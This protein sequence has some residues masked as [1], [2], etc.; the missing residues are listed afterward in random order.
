MS[1]AEGLPEGLGVGLALAG[2]AGHV[3]VDV[4]GAVD[5]QVVPVLLQLHCIQAL[6]QRLPHVVVAVYDV[7]RKRQLVVSL[8]W[9]HLI[10]TL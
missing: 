9:G 6:L 10:R 7:L 8:L 4:H 1:L 2:D 5:L 3:A